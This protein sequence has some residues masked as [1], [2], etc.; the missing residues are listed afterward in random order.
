MKCPVCKMQDL[1]PTELEESLIAYNCANCGGD[2]VRDSQYKEWRAKHGVDLPEK[3]V[4]EREKIQIANVE[5]ARLCPDCRRI[6][7]KY[8]VG[9]DINFTLDRCGGCGGVWLDKDEWATL[10]E[11]NLHDNL[12]DFFTE[13]WQS[14]VRREEARKNMEFISK[15]RFGEEDYERIK[16]FKDWLDKH[17]MRSEILAFL[18]DTDPFDA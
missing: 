15:S 13:P 17:T 9:R 12:Y 3:H 1:T 2:W 16:D 10:K 6:L 7:I 11:R 4:S 5:L 14:E 18:S 8:K